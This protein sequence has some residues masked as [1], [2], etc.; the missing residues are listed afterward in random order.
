MRT[1]VGFM[2]G[3]PQY[4]RCSKSGNMDTDVEWSRYMDYHLI[5]AA[6]GHSGRV[7]Q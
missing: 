2:D 6:S 3:R 7:L 4:D 1:S 5:W